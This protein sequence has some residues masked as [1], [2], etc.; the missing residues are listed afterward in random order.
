MECDMKETHEDIRARNTA[1]VESY[2]Q[3]DYTRVITGWGGE[4]LA[5][6]FRNPQSGDEYRLS[7]QKIDPLLKAGEVRGYNLPLVRLA[8]AEL[9]DAQRQYRVRRIFNQIKE[10]LWGF[11]RLGLVGMG[12]A[13]MLLAVSKAVD[14]SADSAYEARLNAAAS[15]AG[16]PGLTYNAEYRTYVQ[17]TESPRQLLSWTFNEKG[18]LE[19]ACSIAVRQPEDGALAWWMVPKYNSKCISGEHLSQLSKLPAPLPR[20][21]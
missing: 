20:P 1:L 6:A 15:V 10:E 13:T 5:A 7:P 3:A 14:V 21:Q 8:Q 9:A 16:H 2:L 11:S 4:P 17:T 18:G 19:N 12:A